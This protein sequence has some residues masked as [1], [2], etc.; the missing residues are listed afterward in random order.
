[1]TLEQAPLRLLQNTDAQVVAARQQMK[2]A[3]AAMQAAQAARGD[4]VREF[5]RTEFPWLSTNKWYPQADPSAGVC[6]EVGP[7]PVGL[8]F[9][10]SREV[11][12]VWPLGLDIVP[13]PLSSKVSWR[14]ALKTG[15]DFWCKGV[16]A[17]FLQEDYDH[18]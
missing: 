8:S 18:S 1:M 5:V 7:A 9:T 15:S 11:F 16:A 6:S 4:A 12:F 14:E 3:E 13:A 2:A 10:Y 17:R